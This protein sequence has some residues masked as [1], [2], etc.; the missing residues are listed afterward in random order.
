MNSLDLRAQR[1]P[2]SSWPGE[3]PAIHGWAALQGKTW[4]AA[5]SAAMTVSG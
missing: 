4:M 2:S 1:H 5:P 3:V